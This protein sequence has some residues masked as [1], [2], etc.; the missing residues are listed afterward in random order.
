MNLGEQIGKYKIQTKLGAGGMGEVF[1][2]HDEQLDRQVVLKFLSSQFL[3]NQE[4]LQRFKQE[5][6]AASALNH[7][8]II[9][10][11]EIGESNGQWFIATEYIKG[12]TLRELLKYSSLTVNQVIKICQQIVNA[13]VAAHEA[14]IV[15]RDIKPENIML[16]DDGLVK[17]LDFG[18]A[19]LIEEKKEELD[20]EAMT[21]A[22]VKTS[23]GL[24]LGTLAY[25][26]PEQARGVAIDN[27]TDIWSVGVVLYEMLTGHSP[28][29][30]E[31]TSDIIAAILK[32]EVNSV[33]NFKEKVP[34]A[35][36]LIISKALEKD[37]EKR[38]QNIKELLEELK[39]AEKLYENDETKISV[40]T[41]SRISAQFGDEQTTRMLSIRTTSRFQT[42]LSGIK[43]NNRKFI[44]GL[45]AFLLVTLGLSYWFYQ[46]Q[47]SSVISN[48]S[49][50]ESLAVIPFVNVGNNTETEYLSDGITESLITSLSK[51]PR[52]T[53]KARSSVFRYKGKEVEFQQLA[54]ELSVQAILTGRVTQ[55][56]DNLSLS[57]ELVDAKSG[58]LLWGETYNRKM[59]EAAI[60]QNDIVKEISGKLRSEL[61]TSEKANINKNYTNNSEAYQLYLKGRY[62]LNKRTPE[63]F[64]KAIQHFRQAIDRE[65]NYAP[66]YAGL[67]ACYMEMTYW[68]MGLPKEIM[69]KA[70]AA[71]QKALELDETLSE[72]HTALAIVAEDFEWNFKLAE[73]EYLRA[74]E[75]NPNNANAFDQYGGF[76]CEQKRF[77]EGMAKLNKAFE[78][79]PLALG[80]EMSKGACLY[81]EKRYDEAIAQL[82]KILKTEPNYLPASSLLGAIYLRKGLY[83]KTVEEWLK[84]SPLENYSAEDIAAWKQSYETGGIKGFLQKDIEFRKIAAAKGRN[85]TLFIAMQYANSGNNEEALAWLERAFEE[86]HSW[87]GELE[88]EPTWDNLRSDS[89]FQNL[90]QR[91]GFEKKNG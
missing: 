13:L 25:M 51:L 56:D 15:H 77:S 80:I 24:I 76:L 69:P 81:Q 1:L 46:A 70:R 22:Q 35:L 6:R 82:Q 89:R 62:S 40:L 11:Y 71:A 44:L 17:V 19:K 91:I 48:P 8:N 16:R 61:S 32:T 54:G 84:N 31:T 78:L 83:D 2:A 50:I 67:S 10:I 45:G 14:G 34:P 21:R 58:N 90:L 55:R 88:V 85:Q 7:P 12:K 4:L 79:D 42:F 59:G 37:K 20:T 39:K 36:E 33:T 64:E 63:D 27:R 30:G 41:R 43:L 72:G 66:A 3:D 9:T 5:A 65:P 18:L 47:K 60:L 86:R 57:L 26:S 49:Q 53:V 23:V 28:F 38:Y 74:I 73:K 87:L 68:S 29:E 75:L 52:L